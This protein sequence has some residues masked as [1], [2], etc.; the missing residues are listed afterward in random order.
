VSFG[1]VA[2]FGVVVASSDWFLEKYFLTD[3]IRNYVGPDDKLI[4]QVWPSFNRS[5]NSPFY[6]FL[7]LYTRTS[8]LIRTS[9]I[10]LM[11]GPFCCL[12]VSITCR[13]V[14]IS[15][16]CFIAFVIALLRS[17]TVGEGLL[18][19]VIQGYVPN[20]KRVGT[21]PLGPTISFIA[22]VAICRANCLFN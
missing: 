4:V 14:C 21:R 5:T 11:F 8:P 18:E 7:S 17:V 13:F 1:G 20:T 9:S 6:P 15:A 12:R 3:V 2:S 19:V 16:T 22:L 10:L